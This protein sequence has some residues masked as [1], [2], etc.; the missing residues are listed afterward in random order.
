MQVFNI[1]KPFGKLNLGIS[2]VRIRLVK[3]FSTRRGCP[4]A[5]VICLRLMFALMP[6]NLIL[7]SVLLCTFY[8]LFATP[9][10]G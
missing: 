3:A 9:G 10:S 8:M 5:L 6:K 2:A 4:L 1:S 7:F